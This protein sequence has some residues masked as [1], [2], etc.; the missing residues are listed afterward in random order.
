MSDSCCSPG[1]ATTAAARSPRYRRILWAALVINAAMFAVELA[2]GLRADS[3]SLLAD[4]IDFF[5][6]AANYGISLLVLGM[7]AGLRS[8]AAL[9]KGLTMGAFGIFVLGRVAWSAATGSA[10][11]PVTMGAIGALALVANVSVALML[12]AWREGDANMRSVWLCSRNDAIGNVA[13]MAAAL[14]VFGTGS[15]WPDLAVASVMGVLG[16]S[17]ARSVIAQARGELRPAKM[18]A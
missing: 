4:A 3:V 2:G 12:Y 17:A 1:C 6:D 15:G 10:P 18:R 9:F 8:R 13:V 11:Q 7:A 16:L 14:G 5:G